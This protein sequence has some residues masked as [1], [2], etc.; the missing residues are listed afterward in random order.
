MKKRRSGLQVMMKLIGLVRPLTGY[1]VLAVLMGLLGH[2][3]ASF[4][5]ICA[6]FAVLEA[7]G[8]FAALSMPWIF[9]LMI[10]L[11]AARAFLRY[12]EQKMNHYIAFKLLAR[13]RDKVFGALRR[14]APAKLDGRTKLE[15]PPCFSRKEEPWEP[16][17]F[18]IKTGTRIPITA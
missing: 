2:L 10:V 8:Q 12:G 3:C 18:E 15:S 16:L 14:L 11:A 5:T 13:I 6:G 4:I 1:M 9:A 17:A 7:L